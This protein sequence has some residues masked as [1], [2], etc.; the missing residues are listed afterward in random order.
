MTDKA[1]PDEPATGPQGEARKA[2]GEPAQMTRF[3]E[4]WTKLWLDELRAQ[5]ADPQAMADG[6]ELWRAAMALWTDAMGVRPARTGG[7]RPDDRTGASRAQ[8]VAA[9]SDAGDAA[10]E[11]LARRIDELEARLARL[12]THRPPTGRSTGRSR[13]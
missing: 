7:D 1:S 2:P 4:D 13:G 5:S 6:M 10:I 12:E 11:R 8:T 9:A 3:L